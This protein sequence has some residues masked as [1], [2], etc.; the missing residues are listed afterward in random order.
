MEKLTILNPK[1]INMDSL[2]GRSEW[3]AADMSACCAGANQPGLDLLI[4]QICGE[5]E[6]K[7]LYDVFEPEAI[8]VA[9][10]LK[11]SLTRSGLLRIEVFT[12]ILLYEAV[13]GTKCPSCRGTK[14]SRIEPTKPCRTCRGTGMYTL[15]DHAKAKLMEISQQAYTK[16]WRKREKE[17][18]ALFDRRIYQA[19]QSIYKKLREQ[20]LT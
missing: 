6:Y 3:T 18:K 11:W 19:K 7:A 2:G 13:T 1:S 4:F 16:T 5:G 15:S 8:R 9:K 17:I 12:K 20:S 10:R 14:F